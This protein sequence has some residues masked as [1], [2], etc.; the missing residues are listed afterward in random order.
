M[1]SCAS[2]ICGG[3]VDGDIGDDDDDDDD[4]YD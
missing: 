2:D 3:D 4:D 1:S